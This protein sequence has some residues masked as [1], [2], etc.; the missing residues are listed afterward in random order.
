MH[1]PGSH[2]PKGNVTEQWCWSPLPKFLRKCSVLFKPGYRVKKAF[3]S[4]QQKEFHGEEILWCG[5]MSYQVP[6]IGQEDVT[7]QNHQELNYC[8]LVTSVVE[9]V[10]V[11]QGKGQD[12]A[13]S[14]GASSIAKGQHSAYL[15]QTEK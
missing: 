4:P 6:S 5:T 12:S 7:Y 9:G 3:L 2:H 15:E 10:T 14:W 13:W 11:L 8:Q 1:G